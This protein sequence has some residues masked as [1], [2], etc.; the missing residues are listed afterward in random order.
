M[1]NLLISTGVEP[2]CLA[3]QWRRGGLSKRSRRGESV[4]SDEQVS[5]PE[6]ML[7]DL[8]LDDPDMIDLVEEFIDGLQGR[9]NEFKTAYEKHD[10]NSLTT[11]AHQLKGAGGSYGYTELSRFGKT[12]EDAFRAHSA[13]NFSGW[14]KEFEQLINAARAGLQ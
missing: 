7:S 4:N 1:S 2:V 9:V 8:L 5:V 12:L 14:M 11:L 13:D 3:A 6:K 10:W